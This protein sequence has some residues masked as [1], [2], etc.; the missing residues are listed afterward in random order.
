MCGITGII[1]NKHF[2]NDIII[3]MTNEL[4]HRGPDFQDN[5]SKNN[6]IFLGHSRLAI[7]D[8]SNKGNQPMLS[9]SNRYV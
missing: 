6:K 8:L 3:S 7:L 5:W 2:N 1:S 9:S 4:S